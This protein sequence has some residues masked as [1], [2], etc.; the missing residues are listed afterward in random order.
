MFSDQPDKTLLLKNLCGEVEI[1]QVIFQSK[2]NGSTVSN[3]IM[4]AKFIIFVV[5]GIMQGV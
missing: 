4:G 1:T 2:V 5:L 3:I